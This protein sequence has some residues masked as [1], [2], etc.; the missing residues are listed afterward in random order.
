M[1]HP[2]PTRILAIRHGETS[3]N[4]QSRVQGQLD[5]ELND[6]GRWQA[7]RL[8]AAL[9]DEAFAA[10]YASDLQRALDTAH[11]LAARRGLLLQTERGL[12]E[13]GFGE[14]E[15]LTFHD[16]DL[17]WP[18]QAM[19][20]RHRDPE[21]GPQGGETLAA[22]YARCV[23]TVTRL[24]AAHPGQVIALVAHGGVLDC[25]YR[26]AARVDLRAPRTWQLGN[27]SINR[28][29][30]TGE[31]FTLVGWSDTSHLDVPTLDDEPL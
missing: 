22:F 9:A 7:E 4:V 23:G 31:G 6:T 25:M 18:E 12:R 30:F 16:I 20:W 13:R 21:F 15:G 17:R 5:I 8:A 26:A 29:L 10:I 14:F 27:A 28:L 11:A 24:A 19:R 3:W 2:E 1:V